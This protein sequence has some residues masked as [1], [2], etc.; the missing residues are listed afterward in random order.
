MG[1]KRT[2]FGEVKEIDYRKKLIKVSNS[3]I[4]FDSIDEIKLRL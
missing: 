2:S 4:D 1:F 3:I